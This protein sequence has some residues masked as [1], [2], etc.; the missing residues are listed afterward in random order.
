MRS[1]RRGKKMKSPDL[2]AVGA[3]TDFPGRALGRDD[4]QGW[5]AVGDTLRGARE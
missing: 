4:P 1:L 5:E 2:I 3:M